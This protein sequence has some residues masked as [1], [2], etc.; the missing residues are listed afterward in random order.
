MRKMTR[1]GFY[2]P[3]DAY[4]DG[5]LD[6]GDGHQIYFEQSGNP[7]GRPVIFLHGG[8]GGGCQVHQKHD[9]H[10]PRP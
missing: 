5:M 3:I 1:L 9:R 2:P 6:V 10:L 4:A 7:E 8:P